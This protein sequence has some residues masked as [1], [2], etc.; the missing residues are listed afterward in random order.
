MLT[1]QKRWVDLLA[2]SFLKGL[3]NQNSGRAGPVRLVLLHL[4]VCKLVLAVCCL[5][6][7]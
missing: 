3:Q 1:N 6:G 4:R 2:E 7:L 5:P